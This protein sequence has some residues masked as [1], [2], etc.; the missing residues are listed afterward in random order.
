MRSSC[1]FLKQKKAKFVN[2]PKKTINFSWDNLGF[3]DNIFFFF[4]FF[5]FKYFFFFFFKFYF[6]RFTIFKL[7]F[8]FFYKIFNFN[9][10]CLFN[11]VSMKKKCGNIKAFRVAEIT[12]FGLS[13]TTYTDGF[14]SY[15][16]RPNY[17]L[18]FDRVKFFY[19]VVHFFFFRKELYYISAS[20]Y[21]EYIAGAAFFCPNLR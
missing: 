4:F 6:F 7:Y 1:F 9:L 12:N 17:V 5:F 2:N 21:N 18:I 16:Y 14:F 8:V 13:F 20:L 10:F 15:E 3:S 19:K 11:S